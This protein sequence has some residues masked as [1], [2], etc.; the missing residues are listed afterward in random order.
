MNNNFDM[1]FFCKLSFDDIPI[2][3]PCMHIYIIGL[4]TLSST[5]SSDM[6]TT[7][8][9][10]L[11]T[12][13]SDKSTT[14]SEPLSTFSSDMPTT[15]SE[16]PLTPITTSSTGLSQEIVITIAAIS[17]MLAAGLVIL[18]V[19]QCRRKNKGTPSKNKKNHLANKQNNLT[20]N[21]KADL[22]SYKPRTSKLIKKRNKK[23]G[24]SSIDKK[25][26]TQLEN[27]APKD[28]MYQHYPQTTNFRNNSGNQHVFNISH[29]EGNMMLYGN[30]HDNYLRP[31][32]RPNNKML[33]QFHYPEYQEH[34][35]GLFQYYKA[36]NM[37][38]DLEGNMY[39]R[40]YGELYDM[41]IIDDKQDDNR[42]LTGRPY[43]KNWDLLY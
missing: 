2:P 7:V 16:A 22:K 19:V 17:C 30:W 33:Y 14:V 21:F 3:C 20:K 28:R 26:I 1:R 31:H 18:L 40:P 24:S 6:S 8:S 42:S 5:F 10:P 12:I 15:L 9:E 34:N 25:K 36:D 13:H 39:Q 32:S 27:F 43:E 29:N 4:T 23:Q 11:S 41:H 38:P 35:E 37:Y